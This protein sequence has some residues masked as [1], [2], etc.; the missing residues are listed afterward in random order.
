MVSLIV[1]VYEGRGTTEL[2]AT[3]MNPLSMPPGSEAQGI[4][5]L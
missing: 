5:K 2:L 3:G 4:A 1:T